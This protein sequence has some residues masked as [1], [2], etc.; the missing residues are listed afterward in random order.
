MRSGA[1]GL[2]RSAALKATANLA[3][4]P[5]LAIVGFFFHSWFTT[6]AWFVTGGFFV[7]DNVAAGNVWKAF[8]AVVYGM[9]LLIGT[10]L[11]ILAL[12]GVMLVLVRGLWRRE[13]AAPLVLLA[14]VA[15][16]ALPAYAFFNGHP[17]RM[18]YMVAPSVGA[19]VFAG[20][21]IGML[22]GRWRQ[23]AAAAMA[24]WLVATVKPLDAQ[25]PM[26]LEA[27]WDVPF[28]L[29]RRNVTACL[30]REYRGER[31]LASMGSLAHYMQ[32]LSQAGINIR[33]FVHEGTL[34]YWHEAI[35][36]P[37]G[38]VGWIL[39]EERAEG[40]DMLAKRV[41]ESSAFTTGFARLCAD[42]G[43]ALYKAKLE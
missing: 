13:H 1:A 15:L 33:D 42:G 4:Y 19:T 22:K 16:M 8:M 29:G 3:I 40:G 43:V 34:P 39:V 14:L 41:R 5:V 12:A 38:R 30:A 9:R 36:A 2:S 21:A 31:I 27:Q 7:P 10:P 28:S 25:A 35:E 11:I 17:F 26:V 6:G 18:R 24:V 37:Q 32:E 20:V 23:A